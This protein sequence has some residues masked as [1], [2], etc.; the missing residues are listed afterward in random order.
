MQIFRNEEFGEI[1]VVVEKNR[2]YF[3]ATKVAEILGYSNPRKAVLDHCNDGVTI[4]DVVVV[5]GI[6]KDGSQSTKRVKK[7]FIDEGNLYR[8]IMRS[9]LESAKKFERWVVNEVLPNLRR[10]GVYM[11]EEIIENIIQNPDFLIKVAE[12]LKKEKLKVHEL[13]ET[14]IKC[15]SLKT[16]GET[17]GDCKDAISIGAFAKVLHGLGIEI[18]RNR[19]FAWL[20]NNGYLM[21]QYLENQPKQMYIEQ[22][23]FKTRQTIINTEEEF[24]IRITTYITGKGQKYFIKLIEEDFGYGNVQKYV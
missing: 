22:G 10:N 6:K 7:K 4:R 17:I 11:N 9:K 14:I 13:N 20:R 2:E 21:S 23:L 12:N 8:L 3:E 15:E 16:L 19:L 1:S 5:A 18:G 24:K